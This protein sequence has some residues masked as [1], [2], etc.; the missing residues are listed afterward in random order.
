MQL[1]LTT[2][3]LV[4]RRSTTHRGMVIAPSFTSTHGRISLATYSEGV[5][6][7]LLTCGSRTFST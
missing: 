4:L 7:S 2:Q 1:S 6:F 3:A 5:F